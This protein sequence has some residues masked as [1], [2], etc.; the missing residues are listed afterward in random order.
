MGGHMGPP[1]WMKIMDSEKIAEVN[2]KLAS[3]MKKK[4]KPAGPFDSLD[5]IFDQGKEQQVQAELQ[6]EFEQALRA[7]VS[8][9]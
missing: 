5:A 4:V 1:R 9:K 2:E 6:A 7:I 3:L 8:G